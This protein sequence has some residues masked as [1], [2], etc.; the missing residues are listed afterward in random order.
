MVKKPQNGT[1]QRVRTPYEPPKVKF[2]KLMLSPCVTTS[3]SA[4][5]KVQRLNDEVR[6]SIMAS[7]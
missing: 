4:S 3:I 1:D 2:V 7:R 5:S 6:Q